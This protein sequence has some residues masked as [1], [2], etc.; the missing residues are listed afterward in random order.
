MQKDLILSEAEKQ[1]RRQMVAKNRE[2]R[3][4]TPKTNGLDLVSM[5]IS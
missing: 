3:K 4:I 2:K 5:N 1:T